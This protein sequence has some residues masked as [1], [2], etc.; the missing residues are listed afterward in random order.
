M[1]VKLRNNWFAPGGRRFRK[2][3]DN[4]AVSIPDEFFPFLPKSAVV[5]EPPAPA[6]AAPTVIPA[7]ER[8]EPG[9]VLRD[10]DEDRASLE[11]VDAKVTKAE[12]FRKA[13]ADEQAGK[14]KRRK[15]E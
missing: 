7:V 2:D 4:G 6:P 14:G 10:L 13:L 12:Q 8:P 9:T 3:P 11:T 5:V 1:Q 15:A